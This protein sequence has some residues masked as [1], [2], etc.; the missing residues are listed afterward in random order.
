MAKSKPPEKLAGV[1]VFPSPVIY[2][3][4]A[5]GGQIHH[6]QQ[7]CLRA[8]NEG[9]TKA[10]PLMAWKMWLTLTRQVAGSDRLR[11]TFTVPAATTSFQPAANR[12]APIHFQL[13]FISQHA[14]HTLFYSKCRHEKGSKETDGQ[15]QRR[16]CFCWFVYFQQCFQPDLAVRGWR[17]MRRQW[18][19]DSKIILSS[20]E[21]RSVLFWVALPQSEWCGNSVGNIQEMLSFV[22][23]Q[24]D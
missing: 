1:Y 8:F 17:W 24:M 12:A 22:D 4:Q 19:G 11:L 16:F 6:Y 2:Q 10:S 23:L 20:R 3:T 5:L 21:K 9:E 18:W 15:L 13:A 7:P 14:P